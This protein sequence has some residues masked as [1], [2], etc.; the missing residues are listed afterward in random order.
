MR[1]YSI[2]SANSGAPSVLSCVVSI[3]LRASSHTRATMNPVSA[4]TRQVSRSRTLTA[5]N[6]TGWSD[7]TNRRASFVPA[8]MLISGMRVGRYPMRSNVKP[9]RP[10]GTVSVNCPV[11]VVSARAAVVPCASAAITITLGAG[12]DPSGS[13]TVP[14]TVWAA[15]AIA[16]VS[17]IAVMDTSRAT[18]NMRLH[19][20]D[21]S[22]RARQSCVS[23]RPSSRPE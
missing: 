22:M 8:P 7:K 9:Y 4:L 15:T 6:T 1:S 2:H 11:A 16:F 5:D 23:R 12:V 18:V 3:A 10:A 17:T 20:S 21:E 14:R 13:T 19:E